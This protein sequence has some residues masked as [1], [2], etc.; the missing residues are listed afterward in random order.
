MTFCFKESKKINSINILLI[1]VFLF[2]CGSSQESEVVE[3]NTINPPVVST[4]N[5]DLVWSDEFDGDAI[6]ETKWGF[7]ENCWGGGNAEQQCYTKRS[8]NAFVSDG[9]LTILAQ[10]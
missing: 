6:D 10:R 2:A 3:Q 9:V 5:W 4:G 1:C 7:E 8:D